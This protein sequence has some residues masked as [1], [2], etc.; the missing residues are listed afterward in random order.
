MR[1][2][3]W[4]RRRGNCRR[5]D[6]SKASA[7]DKTSNSEQAI[8]LEM[9]SGVG[10]LEDAKSEKVAAENKQRSTPTLYR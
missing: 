5:G 9:P 8:D 4:C 1:T 3:R 7:L 10:L 6:D 2:V